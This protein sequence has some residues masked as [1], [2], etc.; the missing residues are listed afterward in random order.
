MSIDDMTDEVQ[1][2]VSD[3]KHW[4]TAMFHRQYAVAFRT[5]RIKENQI[6]RLIN[7][8]LEAS[9]I[10]IVRSNILYVSIRVVHSYWGAL[11]VFMA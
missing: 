6:L 4:V 11:G 1:C 8:S 2:K 7:C 3:G 10:R 9:N 5:G